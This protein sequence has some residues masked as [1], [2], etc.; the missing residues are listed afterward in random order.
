MGGDLTLHQGLECV[1]SK[2]SLRGTA[3]SSMMF[4]RSLQSPP[5]LEET[6]RY[7]LRKFLC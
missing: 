6:G 4:I 1:G 3:V 2:I 7:V 5:S